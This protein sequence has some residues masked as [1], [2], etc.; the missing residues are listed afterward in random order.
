M[1]PLAGRRLLVTRRLEQ[2]A[3]LAERL[4]ALGAE[5]A[6][7]PT[8]VIAPPEDIRPLDDCLARAANYDWWAFT[9]AN[10]VRVVRERWRA[11]AQQA[12]SQIPRVAT[13]GTATTSAFREAFDWPIALQPEQDFRAESLLAAFETVDVSG[14]RILLPLSDRARDVLAL[15][16]RNRGAIVDTPIA[17]RTMAPPGLAE[18]LNALLQTGIDL[19]IFASPS[20]VENL[21]AASPQAIRGL[22][23]AVM[24]PITAEAA[25]KQG[26]D[27]QVLADP[28][29]VEGLVVAL[30]RWPQTR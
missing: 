10:A 20:A 21:A 24:G 27:V 4:R 18:S 8:I 15:G 7:L 22:P 6:E 17:Y 3:E 16:L 25:R 9:S 23:A 12:P 26:L 5:V 1:K 13:V 19:A 28:S 11:L 29:T 14:T 2:S 30:T